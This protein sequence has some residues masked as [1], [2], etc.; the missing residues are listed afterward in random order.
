MSGAIPESPYSSR[1]QWYVVIL[2]T[3]ASTLSFIDRQILN[4]MIGPIKRD[5]GDISDTE[6]SLIIG[7][8]F[9]VIYTLAT[10]PLARAAD[11]RNLI[12][13]G[14]F[15]WSLMTA[16]AGKADNFRNLFL[17]RM[18]VGIGEATLGPFR[19]LGAPG[20]FLRLPF[21]R[22]RRGAQRPR[23]QARGRLS[24][25]KRRRA[26]AG[27]ATLPSLRIGRQ[28][29]RARRLPKLRWI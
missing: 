17:A 4:V 2:L 6:I 26:V 7:L 29:R 10:L 5:L 28:D 16:L 14:I 9:S 23:R 24:E 18:G 1:T 25:G 15:V 20:H 3:V 27:P 13:A 12:A 11:H 22:E 19:L 8:A 21:R